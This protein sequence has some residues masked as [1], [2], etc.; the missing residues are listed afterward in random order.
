MQSHRLTGEARTGQGRDRSA[1]EG[2]RLSR[3]PQ[4]IW[5]GKTLPRPVPES[6]S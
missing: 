1:I 4:I 3:L 5:D 6:S 2:E